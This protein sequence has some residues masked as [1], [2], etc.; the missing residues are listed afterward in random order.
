MSGDDLAVRSRGDAAEA[1]EVDVGAVSTCVAVVIRVVEVD[2]EPEGVSV[3]L[4]RP[5]DVLDEEYRRVTSQGHE[6]MMPDRSG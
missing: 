6:P 3:V 2:L 5:A 1:G 4:G